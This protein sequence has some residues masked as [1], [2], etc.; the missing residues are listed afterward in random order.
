[1]VYRSPHKSAWAHARN[2][3]IRDKLLQQLEAA[4]IAG[5][6]CPLPSRIDL[7]HNGIIA[8]LARAGLIKLECYTHGR[9]VEIT[10][11]PHAGARTK[12]LGYPGPPYLVIDA[13][14]RHWHLHAGMRG[15]HRAPSQPKLPLQ[16]DEP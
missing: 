1:M 10:S 11:G 13:T 5:G 12:A 7:R 14:G 2:L 9:V 4:A 15:G 6:P 8:G 16:R 3:A